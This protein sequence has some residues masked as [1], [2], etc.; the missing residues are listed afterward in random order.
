MGETTGI[1]WTDHTFN[2]WWGCT[3]VSPGCHACYALRD[4]RRYGQDQHFGKGAPRRRFGDKHWN[5]PRRW[6]D[7][8][9]RDG[10]KRRVFCASM[11]DVFDAD[12]PAEDRERLWTLISE[13]P[14]LTWMLLTKRPENMAAM[15]PAGWDYLRDFVWLGVTAED[16]QRA[17]ERVPILLDTPAAVRFV[18]VEPMLEAVDLWGCPGGG[19][20]ITSAFAWGKGINWVI[21]GAESGPVRRE[22]KPDWLRSLRDQCVAAGVCFFLKQ[23][24]ICQNCGGSGQS[25][26]NMGSTP[27]PCW[28]CNG[29]GQTGKLV[30]MPMLDGKVWDQIPEVSCG[31]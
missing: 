6:N 13:T 15:L 14:F 30:K 1:S 3:P 28:A 16:Q 21:A 29:T 20:V 7:K 25:G 4:A 27:I 5:E 9:L 24:D 11:A 19:G 23:A 12:G 31:Q 22:C 17:D 10:V 2:P 8:A 18:S 26:W